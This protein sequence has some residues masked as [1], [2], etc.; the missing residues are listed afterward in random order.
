MIEERRGAPGPA[1]LSP[2]GAASRAP[3]EG[4]QRLEVLVVED[5][6]RADEV[7][8]AAASAGR[9]A[10]LV[11]HVVRAEN[12]EQVPIPDRAGQR[13]LQARIPVREGVVHVDRQHEA[14]V[15]QEE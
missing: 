7:V 5:Q 15:E 8:D 13:R 12:Q 14:V 10:R 4:E 3:Y 9:G 11:E 1:E 6:L 2:R